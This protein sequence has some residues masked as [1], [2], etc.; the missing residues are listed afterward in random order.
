MHGKAVTIDFSPVRLVLGAAT[1][2]NK[3]KVEILGQI[4]MNT[5]LRKSLRKSSLG[6]RSIFGAKSLY[7]E[8]LRDVLV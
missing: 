1:K 5:A 6:D 7:K 3:S 4:R 8:P 2:L